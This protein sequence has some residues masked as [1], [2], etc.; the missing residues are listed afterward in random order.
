MLLIGHVSS[1]AATEAVLV[2][3]SFAHHAILQVIVS[4]YVCQTFI[5][6]KFRELLDVLGAVEALVYVN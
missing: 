4:V 2:K 5:F 6:G 1:V 3:I